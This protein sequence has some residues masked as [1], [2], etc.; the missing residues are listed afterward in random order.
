[1]IITSSLLCSY[2]CI[3]LEI[4]RQAHC[5]KRTAEVPT[6]VILSQFK[7]PCS[8][9][10]RLSLFQASLLT[11]S[12]EA[13]FLERSG[14]GAASKKTKKNVSPGLLSSSFFWPPSEYGC[15]SFTMA[16]HLLHVSLYDS[17]ILLFPILHEFFFTHSPV[18]SANSCHICKVICTEV[19]FQYAFQ[20]CILPREQPY[21][22]TVCWPFNSG[23]SYED[24]RG[25]GAL[26]LQA[27][28]FENL[29][30]RTGYKENPLKVFQNYS[31][32][33]KVNQNE[34]QKL[35]GVPANTEKKKY[36]V[37]SLA[38][39]QYTSYRPLISDVK[40]L[41]LSQCRHIPAASPAFPMLTTSLVFCT[42][43]SIKQLFWPLRS[44][45]AAM[46]TSCCIL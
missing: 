15:P 46:C 23:T 21:R 3:L 26:G 27:F 29:R 2:C 37:P 38:T 5:C 33:P 35:N 44:C 25:S 40:Q 36:K 43:L 45:L 42:E 31:T 18:H 22:S 7:L 32:F 1:M 30:P 28:S 13:W 16:S 20:K 14:K 17:F 12:M 39:S 41:N 11:L 10:K 6:P 9:L 19:L 4:Y 34:P 8:F 24:G